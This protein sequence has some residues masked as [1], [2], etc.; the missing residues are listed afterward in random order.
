[1]KILSPVTITWLCKHNT[2]IP[3]QAD[4][5]TL[6][7]QNYGGWDSG[8]WPVVASILVQ[9]GVVVTM[10]AGNYG[11]AGLSAALPDLLNGGAASGTDGVQEANDTVAGLQQKYGAAGSGPMLATPNCA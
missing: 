2:E 7:L 1:M 8:A 4:I 6:S 5:I 10:C 11:E 3:L 9:Q